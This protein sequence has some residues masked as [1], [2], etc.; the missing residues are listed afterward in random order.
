M[1]L[2]AILIFAFAPCLSAQTTASSPPNGEE[3]DKG[4]ILIEGFEGSANGE[5]AVTDLNSTIGYRFDK[6]TRVDAGVPIY[7]I[8]SSSSVTGSGSTSGLGNPYVDLGWAIRNPA[9]NYSTNLNT[10]L[11]TADTK[12]GLSTGRVTFDWDNRFDREFS[13]FTPF[14]DAGVGN[15][16]S[17]RFIFRRPFVSL[18]KAAHFEGG[19]EYALYQSVSVSVSGYDVSPWGRQKVFSRLLKRGASGSTTVRHGRVFENA[20]ETVGGASLTRDTGFKGGVDFTPQSYL[21]FSLGYS[22]SMSYALNTF[23]FGLQVDVAELIQKK[24]GD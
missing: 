7:F 16:L 14:V 19:T 22:R 1:L 4:M 12:K 17:D 13:R 15:S 5:G 20:A 9:V 8:H 6:H 3:Q 21:D 18:G 2:H 24:R 10:A 23:Y 11:P